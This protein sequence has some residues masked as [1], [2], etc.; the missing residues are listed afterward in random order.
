MHERCGRTGLGRT[1][2]TAGNGQT[3][4]ETMNGYRMDA[5]QHGVARAHADAVRVPKKEAQRMDKS[6]RTTRRWAVEGPPQLRQLAL[7]LEDHPGP[8]RILASV[9][10]MADR[11]V[12]SMT[13][14][15]LIHEYRLLLVQE[16]EVEAADRAGSFNGASWLDVAAESERDAA[17][18]LKKAAI[19][20]EFA[21]RRITREAV[22][23]G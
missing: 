6:V 9:S 8:H 16:C 15:D 5:M 11:K 13:D 7:Y 18:D 14:A 2:E 19:E 1:T 22:F 23:H 21:V 4:N 3:R 17:V 10:A 20:R 12:R